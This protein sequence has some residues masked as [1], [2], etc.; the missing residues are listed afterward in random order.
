MLPL[1]YVLC[2]VYF[3]VTWT[4]PGEKGDIVQLYNFEKIAGGRCSLVLAFQL[5][6]NRE[7]Q[8]SAFKRNE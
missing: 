5:R 2:D 3:L 7:F 8:L 4:T 1:G 6:T